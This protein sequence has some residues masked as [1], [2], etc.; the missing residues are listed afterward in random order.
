M[1]LAT[2]HGVL[3]IHLLQA[4][5]S[6]SLRNILENDQVLKIGVGIKNDF[7]VL[8]NDYKVSCRGGLELNQLF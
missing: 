1:Q 5:I 4:G 3:I 8:W 2:E 6:S 7:D